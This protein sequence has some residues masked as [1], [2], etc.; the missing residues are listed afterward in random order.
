[1]PATISGLKRIEPD[2]EFVQ[3]SNSG[4]HAIRA[5]FNANLDT[6]DKRSIGSPRYP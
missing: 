6:Y 1:M 4:N 5:V 2:F 3:T